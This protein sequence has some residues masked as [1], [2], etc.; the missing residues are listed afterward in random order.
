MIWRALY[1][2]VIVGGLTIAYWQLRKRYKKSPLSEQERVAVGLAAFVGAMLGAKL[3]FLLAEKPMGA[4]SWLW[5]ADGKTIL[6]GIFGGYTSVELT[7][8]CLGIKFR[9]GDHFA[10]PVAIAIAFGRL[11]CF[12]GG[13]C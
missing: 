1:P 9:T 2:L 6:G 8:I 12:V 5:L 4:A 7:K 3:P 13:C 10:A 11:G